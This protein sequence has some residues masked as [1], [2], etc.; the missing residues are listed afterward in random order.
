VVAL[1]TFTHA[2]DGVLGYVSLA[3]QGTI[4]FTSRTAPIPVSVL[5]S[6]PFHIKVVLSLDSDK[7]SFPDGNTRTLT[8]DRPTTPVRIQ[9]RSRTSGDRLPVGV[10]LTTPDGQLVLARSALTVHSTSI[11]LVGV[12]LTVL[13]ALVLLVWWGRTWRRSRRRRPRA[14]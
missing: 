1:D 8:L 12:G 11:S 13:A 2:L 14:A 3:I 10:T 5:S 9:A 7:F 6:A 4:T